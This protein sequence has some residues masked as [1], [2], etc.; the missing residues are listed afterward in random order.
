[1]PR[2]A[3]FTE[4]DKTRWIEKYSNERMHLRQGYVS[5]VEFKKNA[6][7]TGFTLVGALPMSGR[8][9]STDLS[10]KIIEKNLVSGE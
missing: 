9:W 1:L 8:F 7:V 5:P 3:R 10:L 6:A 2:T 4:G